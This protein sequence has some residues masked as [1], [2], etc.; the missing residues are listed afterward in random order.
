MELK[1]CYKLEA[2]IKTQNLIHRYSPDP[3][4]L[5]KNDVLLW[6]SS[7]ISD[8]PHIEFW[9]LKFIDTFFRLRSVIR[10]FFQLVFRSALK[11]KVVEMENSRRKLSCGEFPAL[12]KLAL[13]FLL[14]VPPFRRGIQFSN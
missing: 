3:K 1:W 10:A 2:R 8:G 11:T 6:I 14:Y 13:A 9:V 4:S 12:Q 5:F 7:P